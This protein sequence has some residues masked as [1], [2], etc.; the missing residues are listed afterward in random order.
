MSGEKGLAKIKQNATGY[1][2]VYLQL[3][4]GESCDL[5]LFNHSVNAPA[6]VYKK[7]SDKKYDINGKWKV[8]FVKGG[9]EI[10]SS[11]E[12][13]NLVSWTEFAGEKGKKFSG[14]AMYSIIF[15]LPN[16]KCNGWTLDLGKVHE[17]ASVSLNGNVLDTLIGPNFQVFIP[18]RLLKK[19]NLL[20]VKVSNLMANRIID[21]DKNGVNWKKF[22]NINIQTQ[23]PEN[24][25]KDG[26]FTAEKWQPLV[27][28]LIGP[29][30][31]RPVEY[32]K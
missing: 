30:I 2:D 4:P 18:N 20:E 15:N 31:L 7:I 23:Q 13:D 8:E 19:S 5:Q 14:T 32:I 1:V 29:V 6:F 9:P 22:Y 16:I 3:Q 25:S 27:S 26:V 11:A 24:R 10:P 28:G 17:S 12:L 21:L